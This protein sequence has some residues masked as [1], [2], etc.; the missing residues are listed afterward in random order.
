MNAIDRIYGQLLEQF[1]TERITTTQAAE[2]VGLTRGVT[3]NYLSKLHKTGKLIKTG[4]RPVYWQ[5]KR[6]HSAFDD[7]IG[8]NG[9]LSTNIQL[10]IE[11]I[12][13]PRHGLPIFIT[14]PSGSGKLPFA[15][16]I[17][18]ESIRRNV[19]STN[20]VFKLIDCANYKDQVGTLKKEVAKCEHYYSFRYRDRGG[21]HIR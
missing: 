3:S 12:V 1:P 19:L 7:L 20:A 8:S 5:I 18:H 17:Y 14:G 13:Y 4:S 9:S 21:L 16:A 11:A 2:A 10:A 6:E 15:Q